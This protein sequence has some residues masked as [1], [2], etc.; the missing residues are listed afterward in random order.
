MV[1]QVRSLHRIDKRD[2]R[3]VFL[4]NGTPRLMMLTAARLELLR[5]CAARLGRMI[6]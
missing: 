2:D 3:K 1:A 6:E 5:R 4:I